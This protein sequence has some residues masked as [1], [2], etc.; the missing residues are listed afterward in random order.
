[1]VQESMFETRPLDDSEVDIPHPLSDFALEE[2]SPENQRLIVLLLQGNL[3]NV[4]QITRIQ[5]SRD[6]FSMIL[7]QGDSDQIFSQRS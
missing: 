1:M 4:C 7:F 3:Q 6:S 5:G 2:W